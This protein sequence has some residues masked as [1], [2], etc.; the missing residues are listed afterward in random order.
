M[1]LFATLGFS[2]SRH[3][4]L[5]MLVK[6]RLYAPT[7]VHCDMAEKATC[8]KT[9]SGEHLG[10]NCCDDE[11]WAI[12]GIAV[13]HIPEPSFSIETPSEQA[14]ALPPVLVQHQDWLFAHHCFTEQNT[15]PPPPSGR[16][17]LVRHQRF[18]I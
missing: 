6:E 4:C 11:F 12:A 18:L 9:P 5:G 16:E 3:Y 17:I 14:A 2:V 10:H 13:T 1:L 7:P 8:Q 15:G